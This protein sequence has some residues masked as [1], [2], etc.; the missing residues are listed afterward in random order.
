MLKR[1]IYILLGLILVV[2]VSSYALS[3]RSIP[4]QI[5][6]GVSFSKLHSEELGLDWK[7]VYGALLIELQPEHLRLSAHWP[8]VEPEEGRFNFEELDYQIAMAERRGPDVVL[9]V[10]KRTPGWPECHV[11]GWALDLP[12]EEQEAEILAY[13]RAV[14]LRYKDAPNVRYFQVENEPFLKFAEQYCPEL[15][16]EFLK[17]E[18]ALVRELAPDVPILVTDSGE[19]G[20]WYGAWGAGDVF[21]TSVYLYV[22]YPPFGPIRYPMGPGLFRAKQNVLEFFMGEK[23][24]MLIELGLEPWLPKPIVHASLEEQMNRMG[25]DKFT[26]AIDFAKRTGFDEQY[27]WGAEWWYYMRTVHNDSRY[28]DRARELFTE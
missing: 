1:I 21:G 14:V 26:E 15:D 24:T 6:Y 4:E 23:R 13:I 10:G 28:W 16:P 27:L 11:P 17:K 18:I 25:Y 7:E 22:W 9:A 5:T 19:M 3:R 2:A 12:K 8:M 20:K